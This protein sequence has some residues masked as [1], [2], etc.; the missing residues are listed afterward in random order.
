VCSIVL[1]L[2]AHHSGDLIE[3]VGAPAELGEMLSRLALAVIGQ[4]RT[5]PLAV[6]LLPQVLAG[7]DDAVAKVVP[8]DAACQMRAVRRPAAMTGGLELER[9]E[10]ELFEAAPVGTGPWDGAALKV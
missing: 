7:L 10:V 9:G 6:V 8:I 4:H 1:S 3:T 5:G 2:V